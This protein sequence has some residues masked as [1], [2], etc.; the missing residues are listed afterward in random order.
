MLSHVVS[1]VLVSIQL[2]YLL[3]LLQLYCILH[4][5]HSLYP[6]FQDIIDLAL[7]NQHHQGIYRLNKVGVSVSLEHL[8]SN[9]HQT[10]RLE[11][12]YEGAQIGNRLIGYDFLTQ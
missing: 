9:E 3:R 1:Q 7:G 12:I 10:G 6:I 5:V 8:Q 2:I 4:V 11:H